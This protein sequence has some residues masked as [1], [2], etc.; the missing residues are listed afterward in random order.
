MKKF[1]GLIIMMGQIRNSHRKK[2]YVTDPFIEIPIF[3]KIM[4]RRRVEQIMTLLLFKDNSETL[5]PPD[6][7]SKDKV[8]FGLFS[9]KI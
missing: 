8:S 2:Y 5:L 9:S 7:I 1:P 3:P 4:T 6:R